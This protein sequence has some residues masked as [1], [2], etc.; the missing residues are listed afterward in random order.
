MNHK[1]W[2]PLRFEKSKEKLLQHL[3]VF[4]TYNYDP[5]TKQFKP[6][7]AFIKC[8]ICDAVLK[9]KKFEEG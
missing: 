8:M 3:A 7:D 1:P 2:C 4:R 5:K 6:V 9:E